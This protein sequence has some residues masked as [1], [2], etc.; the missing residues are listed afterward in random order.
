MDLFD[1]VK[2]KKN[3]NDMSKPGTYMAQVVKHGVTCAIQNALNKRE[4][5]TFGLT[6]G[7]RSTA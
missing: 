1:T 7:F 4:E 2:M 6:S 5:F 3:S